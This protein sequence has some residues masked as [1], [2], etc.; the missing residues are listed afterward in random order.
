MPEKTIEPA[1]RLALSQTAVWSKRNKLI[2]RMTDCSTCFY[3]NRK[4]IGLVL[5]E[6]SLVKICRTPKVL[7]NC[8]PGLRFCYSGSQADQNYRYSERG[9]AVVL[10]SAS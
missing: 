10:P 5:L 9:M 7:A 1:I 8:S 6:S 4:G 3:L 2:A